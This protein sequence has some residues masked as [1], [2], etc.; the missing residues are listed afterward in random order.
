M[1]KLLA[2]QIAENIVKAYNEIMNCFGDTVRDLNLSICEGEKNKD[3][4][5]VI[6]FISPL[7]E[8]INELIN[9]LKIISTPNGGNETISDDDFLN[10]HECFNSW[11]KTMIRKARQNETMCLASFNGLSERVP[12]RALKN[13][14]L[15]YY[16]G[17][18]NSDELDTLFENIE[19]DLNILEL[20]KE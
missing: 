18:I 12:E 7:I 3:K 11:V 8:K 17:D 14:I 6:E 16:S 15:N 2:K 19:Y 1:E 4:K 10:I 20:L 13:F 5:H 9:A